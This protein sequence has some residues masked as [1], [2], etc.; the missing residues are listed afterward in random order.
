MGSNSAKCDR[1]FDTNNQAKSPRM[2]I[3]TS[4]SISVD[5]FWDVSSVEKSVVSN[6]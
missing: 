4:Q 2:R 5:R 1:A 6:C 3:S